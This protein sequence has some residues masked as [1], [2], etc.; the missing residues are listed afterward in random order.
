MGRRRG[1][2]TCAL[3]PPISGERVEQRRS[4][5]FG[6]RNSHGDAGQRFAVQ[7]WNASSGRTRGVKPFQGPAQ[8]TD[9]SQETTGQRKHWDEPM[10]SPSECCV[11]FRPSGMPDQARWRAEKW[12]PQPIA[13]GRRQSSATA[14][15]PHSHDAVMRGDA[16]ASESKRKGR[17]RLLPLH[18]S[19]GSSMADEPSLQHEPLSPFALVT[20]E[21]RVLSSEISLPSIAHDDDSAWWLGL[22]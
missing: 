6:S 12:P 7:E 4:A 21:Y 19:P 3:E 20:T 14:R 15:R 18:T 13:G 8:E 1:L 2:H 5:R 11:A 22:H 10:S 9:D 17:H 16:V